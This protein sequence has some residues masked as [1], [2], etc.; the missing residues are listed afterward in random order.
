MQSVTFT[1][2]Y[3]VYFMAFVPIMWYGW[4]IMAAAGSREREP[5]WGLGR[6]LQPKSSRTNV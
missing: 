5:G 6:S 4:M 3:D 2:I 1:Q